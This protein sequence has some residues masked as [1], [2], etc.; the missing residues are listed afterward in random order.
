[1]KTASNFPTEKF[2]GTKNE[3]LATKV[4][5]MKLKQNAR[6][7]T[8]VPMENRRH[9]FVEV[10]DK[11]YPFYFSTLWPLG[12]A[13]DYLTKELKLLP[14]TRVIILDRDQTLLDLSTNI[15]DLQ[16]LR[17]ADVIILRKT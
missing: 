11:R 12:K 5:L 14:A 8:G 15:S 9:I 4:A 7:P 1:M 3:A 10:D 2:V 17:D 16:Q 13:L 6:G